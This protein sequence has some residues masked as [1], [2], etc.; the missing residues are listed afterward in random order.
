M[1]TYPIYAF[2]LSVLLTACAT[3]GSTRKAEEARNRLQIAEAMFRERCKTAGEKVYRTVDDVEGIFL[4][5]VRPEKVNF[6]DQFAM[7]DP[8]GS[9]LGGDAYIKSFLRGF[10]EANARLPDVPNPNA[11]R[12][13]AYRFVDAIDPKDGKRYR[14]TGGVKAVGRMDATAPNVKLDL[15]RDPNFDLNIYA[16]VLDRVPATG[17]IPRYSVTYDD[18]STSKEREYWIAGSSLRVIDLHTNEVIAERVGYMMDRG[19]GNIS[20]G[21]SPWLLAANN[22]CPKFSSRHGARS[23]LLQTENFVEKVLKPKLDK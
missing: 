5:K 7:T 19:Q 6:S 11:P 8:Y 9:D 23:Q 14:Y 16:F 12:H 3:P 17:Q 4:M 2:V 15:K 13:I 10:F 20:G 22:A 18:I 21:R 1:K